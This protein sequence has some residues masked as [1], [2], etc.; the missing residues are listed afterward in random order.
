MWDACGV[1]NVIGLVFIKARRLDVKIDPPW[2]ATENPRSA[3]AALKAVQDTKSC[4]SDLE[5]RAEMVDVEGTSLY[6]VV[7][8]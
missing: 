5:S 8:L 3:I 1:C 2:G 6:V 4:A 7:S